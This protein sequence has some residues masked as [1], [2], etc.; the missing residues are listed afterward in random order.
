MIKVGLLDGQSIQAVTFAKQLTNSGYEPILFCDSKLSYGYHTKYAHKKVLCPSTQ[1]ETTDFHNFFLNY[2]ANEKLEV[3]IPMNDYSAKYLSVY[4][5][6]LQHKVKF[7]IPDFPIFMR[8]YNKN[9]LM[10]VCAINNLPH[11]T[12]IDISTLEKDSTMDFNF[13]ALIKPNETTGARGF[14]K[15]NNFVELWEVYE[16][17]FKEFGDCHL[18]E[19]IPG[20][21]MQYKVQLLIKNHHVTNSTVI[22]KHRYYPV[23]GGSSCFNRT[24]VNNELVKICT[25]VLEIIG[26]EGFADFDLIEDPRDGIIKIMEINPRVP[27]CIKASIISGVNFP[28]AIVDLSTDNPIETYIYKPNKYLRYFSIDLLWLISQKN[29]WQGF[30]EWKKQLFS[31]RHFLQ[32]GELSDPVPFIIGTCSGIVKQINPKFRA[33][34]K[35]MNT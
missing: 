23:N 30:K 21:G 5:P 11:P 7:S 6:F 1:K 8:G 9:Q 29:K 3:V 10:Q 32:D 12:T 18:Q 20:G 24:I 4:K 15:V 26:W 13:P 14:K 35:A 2:L 19:L 28:K 16:P 34:K 27:A 31:N 22:E 17:I 25:E 33:S